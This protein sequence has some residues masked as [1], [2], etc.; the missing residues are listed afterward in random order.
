MSGGGPWTPCPVFSRRPPPQTLRPPLVKL[1]KCVKGSGF[2]RFKKCIK[3]LTRSSSSRYTIW[4]TA[5]VIQNALRRSGTQQRGV[6][7][8]F[9][10]T[11]KQAV[12]GGATVGEMLIKNVSLLLGTYINHQSENL[13]FNPISIPIRYINNVKINQFLN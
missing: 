8:S 9:H 12:G 13:T 1:T 3:G 10:T 6:Q 7:Q 11:T 2:V 5:I 4:S